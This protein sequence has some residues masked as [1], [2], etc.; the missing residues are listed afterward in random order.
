MN[1]KFPVD[2][3]MHT[4]VL[5]RW[6]SRI[7]AEAIINE[8]TSYQCNGKANWWTIK[9]RPDISTADIQVPSTQ[10]AHWVLRCAGGYKVCEADVIERS[11]G[12][13]D[14]I[15]LKQGK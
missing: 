3:L 15:S 10:I 2:K 9:E 1:L 14:S 8:S 11:T 7:V 4:S 12:N 5:R 13:T 6:A